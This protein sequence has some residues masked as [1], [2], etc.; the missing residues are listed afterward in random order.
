MRCSDD[1][2]DIGCSCIPFVVAVKLL[3]TTGALICEKLDTVID[4]I[5]VLHDD[6][7]SPDDAEQQILCGA[8]RRSMG[9]THH[10]RGVVDSRYI[11]NRGADRVTKA[12]M[13]ITGVFQK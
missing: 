3:L 5:E 13:C 12:P 8:T 9:A 7:H 1:A 10:L 11:L 6:A 2:N 4:A